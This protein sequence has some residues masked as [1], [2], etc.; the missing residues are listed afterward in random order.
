VSTGPP[1]LL[2]PRVL[3]SLPTHLHVSSTLGSSCLCPLTSMPPPP[4]VLLSLPTHLHASSTRGAP[5]SAHSNAEV[6]N[7]HSRIILG[8]GDSN[9]GPHGS[10]TSPFPWS[11]LQPLSSF[12]SSNH[13]ALLL[14][15]GSSLGWMHALCHFSYAASDVGES[16]YPHIFYTSS[17]FFLLN[18][19]PLVTTGD[20]EDFVSEGLPLTELTIRI[21]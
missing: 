11:H 8:V 10:T 20:F 1:C 9:S 14:V 7:P 16:Y 13:P 19:R 5:V 15:V 12:E 2:H 3:L 6:S 17:F 21:T 4:A 18:P